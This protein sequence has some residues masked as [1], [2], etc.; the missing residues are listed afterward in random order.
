[1]SFLEQE[2]FDIE[3][4]YLALTGFYG[5]LL[6]NTFSEENRTLVEAMSRN[7][8]IEVNAQ[9]NAYFEHTLERIKK[10]LNMSYQMTCL[11]DPS[12][13]GIDLVLK[14]EEMSR[15]I[16][17]SLTMSELYKLE[18]FRDDINR[19]PLRDPK[20]VHPNLFALYQALTVNDCKEL[21]AYR[22]ENGNESYCRYIIGE[23]GVKRKFKTIQNPTIFSKVTDYSYVNL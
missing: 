14:Q 4:S 18:K 23:D 10:G 1:M 5:D 3:K 9:A 7:A 11:L 12:K 19:M 21:H 15:K 13:P 8:K 20:Y 16:F 2:S 17:N 6:R 22:L